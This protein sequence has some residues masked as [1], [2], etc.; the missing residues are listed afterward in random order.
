MED[1]YIELPSARF[2]VAP[3]CAGLNFLLSGIAL[4]TLFAEQMYTG[5]GKRIACVLAAITV[6]L[7]ANIL[8]IIG[9]ITASYYLND[10][11]DINDHYLEGWLFFAVVMSAMMWLGWTFRD[12]I[13]VNAPAAVSTGGQIR[14]T[15]AA[16]IVA[17]MVAAIAVAGFFPAYAAYRTGEP[18]SA[19]SVQIA[20]PKAIG[21]W[22]RI[23]DSTDWNPKFAEADGQ[24]TVRYRNGARWIDLYVAYYAYQGQGREVVAYGNRV[25][26]DGAWQWLRSGTASA[27]IGQTDSTVAT[28]LLRHKIGR[29]VV[30]YSY[31][32]DGR[33]TGNSIFAKLLQAKAEVL[34]GERRAGFVAIAA[35]DGTDADTMRSFLAAIPAFPALVGSP[36]AQ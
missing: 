5:W 4:S 29:R 30:W 26:D 23:P 33:Y 18:S 16:K 24:N 7:A 6:A 15:G 3:G 12:P 21:G 13:P 22:Q 19:G 27:T 9:L 1:V 36:A 25:Y 17:G 34:F 28:M 20:F 35:D 2:W 11:Y 8:R 14:G 32:V 10:I 31:W